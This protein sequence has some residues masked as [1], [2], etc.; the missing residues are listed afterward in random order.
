MKVGKELLFNWGMR[1]IKPFV[2]ALF[3]GSL[4]FSSFTGESTPKV[5]E[6][7]LLPGEST[8]SNRADKYADRY[9]TKITAL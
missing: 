5:E 1:F 8:Q 3:Y 9:D 2:R 6:H 4:A 7:L